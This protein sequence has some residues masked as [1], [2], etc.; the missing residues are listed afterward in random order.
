MNKTNEPGFLLSRVE[1]ES[2]II[3]SIEAYI[4]TY[5]YENFDRVY[6]EFDLETEYLIESH[7]SN[8]KYLKQGTTLAQ[9][10]EESPPYES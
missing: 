2:F 5:L 1:S 4:K 3:D 7:P 9:R 6:S 8:L 10:V